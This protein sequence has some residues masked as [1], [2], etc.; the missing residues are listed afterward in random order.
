[1]PYNKLGDLQV[2]TLKD[3]VTC[4]NACCILTLDN[5]VILMADMDLS[6]YTAGNVAATVPETMR[7]IHPIMKPIIVSDQYSMSIVYATINNK[8]EITFSGNVT[9]GKAHTNGFTFNVSDRYYNS[10]IGNN[11]PQGTSRR[12]S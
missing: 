6:S 8:G 4:D 3:G 9:N 7:P 2:L 11:F 1:M 12:D 10:T 5:D